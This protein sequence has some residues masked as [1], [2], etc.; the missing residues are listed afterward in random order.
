MNNNGHLQENKSEIYH[1]SLI[2]NKENEGSTK[3]T[4]LDLNINIEDN[5]ITT[6]TYDKRDAFTFTVINYPDITGNIPD[7]I[8]YNVIPSQRERA[9]KDRVPPKFVAIG[10]NVTLYV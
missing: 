5:K 6:S 2:L 7:R 8:G 10:R 9:V 4:Y 1:E 3:T